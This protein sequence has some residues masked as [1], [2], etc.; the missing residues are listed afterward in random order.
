MYILVLLQ[1]GFAFYSPEHKT[2]LLDITNKEV[3]YTEIFRKK[4]KNEK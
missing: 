4:V 1:I 2:L 3:K